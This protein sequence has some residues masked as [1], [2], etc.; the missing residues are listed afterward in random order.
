MDCRR[1]EELFSDHLE[2][3][4]HEILRS[5]LETHLAACPECLPLRD[6]MGEVVAELRAF[7]DL[8]PPADLAGRVA[9]AALV[10]PRAAPQALVVRAAFVVPSW[11]QA[12]AAGFALIVLGTFLLVIGPDAPTRAAERMV[13]RTVSAGQ[14]LRARKDRIVEDVRILGVVLTTAFEG[15][16]ERVNDRIEDY[17][18]LLERRR[19]T[20]QEDTKRGSEALPFPVRLAAAF[21]TGSFPGS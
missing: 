13:G 9:G 20:E 3:T 21:R 15:R 4:L 10:R 11:V 12:A 6:A 8:E 16:L 14:A 7:P 17:R 5:E 1:A 18:R 19:G 2:G